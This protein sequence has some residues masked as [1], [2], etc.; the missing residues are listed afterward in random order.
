MRKSFSGT[1]NWQEIEQ[2]VITLSIFNH[3]ILIL[4]FFN[5]LAQTN[6]VNL[7]IMLP[8]VGAGLVLIKLCKDYVDDY[9]DLSKI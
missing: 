5:I 1:P 2:W 9:V 7:M 6:G 3:V 4:E 8:T